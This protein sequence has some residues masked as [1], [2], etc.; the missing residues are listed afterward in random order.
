MKYLRLV[1]DCQFFNAQFDN[2]GLTLTWNLGLDLSPFKFIS[3]ID[4]QIGPM[5]IKHGD[6]VIYVHT[7]MIA[8]TLY[9]PCREISAIRIPRN[10]R[11]I[12]TL[13]PPGMTHTILF[14][15]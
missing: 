12:E 11:F 15:L 5:T 14:T 4:F 13:P 9:N 1:Y 7:N 8:R 6:H 2:E 3:L 10:S